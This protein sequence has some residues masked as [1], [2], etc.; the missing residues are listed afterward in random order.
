MKKVNNLTIGF[1]GQGWIGKNYAYNFEERG[2]NVVRYSLEPE[3]IK[4]KT[5]IKKCDIVFVAV[6]TPTTP[7]GHNDSIVR[8]SIKLIGKGKIAVIKSTIFPGVTS[9]IQK[10]NP[11]KFILNSPEFLSE[12]TASHDA[13]FPKRNIIG[14]P[15]FTKVFRDKAELVLSVL[16]PAPYNKICLSLDAE[17][18]K[19]G[20]NTLGFF[21]VI[22]TNLLYDV[23][24]SLGGNWEDVKEAM[25]ADPDTGPTYMNPIH[26][27]G[28]GAGGGCFIKDF[29]VFRELYE[30]S[31]NDK[32][33]VDVL[34]SLEKKNIE[35]LKKTHKDLDLLSGVY[36]ED[37]LK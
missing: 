16:P 34:R 4:N 17:I 14:I 30:K 31:I 1:I 15:Q 29:A 12:A 18:I 33:G 22:F 3:Y 20:R 28:R 24:S 5:K 35:L 2:F 27:T 23:T 19:Y 37:V 8:N 32:L 7:K 36:G 21:R 13:A 9:L 11:D 6:P 26:K 10:E 25:I